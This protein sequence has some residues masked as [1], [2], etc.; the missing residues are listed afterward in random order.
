VG[1]KVLQLLKKKFEF[2][3]QFPGLYHARCRNPSTLYFFD[4]FVE[5]LKTKI[6]NYKKL[7]HA[8]QQK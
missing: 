8:N 4:V 1:F 6:S 7:S 2:F 3:S 5:V